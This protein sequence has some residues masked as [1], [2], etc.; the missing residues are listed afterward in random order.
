METSSA[1][2]HVVSA[3][4]M[5][6]PAVLA[7]AR[8]LVQ[9]TILLAAYAGAGVPHIA[10]AQVDVATIDGAWAITWKRQYDGLPMHGLLRL[11]NGQ[12]TFRRHAPDPQSA[13][14]DACL[15]RD[16]P[17]GVLST[18]GEEIVL[19]MR[20]SQVV[21]GCPD[22][23]MHLTVVGPTELRG[24]FGSGVEVRAVKR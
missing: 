14:V 17:V 13:R 7:R 8:S 11:A 24:R 18:A 3:R 2:S 4:V 12:G 15:E 9:A 19:S 6:A 10:H 1:K 21:T 16:A 20:A 22:A 23:V 5:K